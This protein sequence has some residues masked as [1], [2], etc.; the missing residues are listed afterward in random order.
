MPQQPITYEDTSIHMT[1]SII[2]HTESIKNAPGFK[3]L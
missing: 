2:L 3:N 1:A